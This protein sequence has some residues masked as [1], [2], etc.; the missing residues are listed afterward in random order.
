MYKADMK[1]QNKGLEDKLLQLYSLN[2]EKTIDIS[3]RPPFLSLLE[4]F[5]NPHLNIPPAIHIAG[6]NGKGSTLAIMKSCIES[7]GLKSHLYSSPHLHQFNERII[8][9]G[10]MID[11]ESLEALIDE[12]LE[13]NDSGEV[14]FFE[15][16][17]AMA[18]SY[19]SRIKADYTLLETGLGGR[20]DC[21]NVISD[22]ILTIIQKISFDHTEYLGETLEQIAL[23]KAGIMKPGV[24]CIIAPQMDMD[25]VLPVFE[26]RAKELDVR[27]YV[28]G[29][30]WS[31]EKV[32]EGVSFS[33]EDENFVFP[34]FSMVG[35]HQIDNAGAALC[36]L[37]LLNIF[38]PDRIAQGLGRV[39][40]PARL[41]KISAEP[42]IWYDGGHNDSA[43]M[44]LREQIKI[45]ARQDDKPLSLI[46]GMKADKDV[47]AFL[48]NLL[49]YAS[50]LSLVPIDA[51]GVC[52]KADNLKD[53]LSQYPHV[54]FREFNS[55]NTVL[56]N[57][58][59]NNLRIL[60]CG[61][62]YLASQIA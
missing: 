16:T 17:S 60:I 42:E 55:V 11:D 7:M 57:Q 56:H 29:R 35:A 20:L 40:W 8:A 32:A 31:V 26:K 18:F 37:K 23:E 13:L 58:N 47:F 3:F 50:S 36:A 46:V 51:V 27:L 43:A 54:D 4:R 25:A 52:L 33:I 49:P 12:A 45:W 1:H 61:S 48:E 5:G 59:D 44:A 28:Y 21:T 2:R 22:P 10:N 24:P 62:L 41:E 34:E 14:T 19:F 15:I 6:T 30:D 39:Y 53:L 38:D 9:A